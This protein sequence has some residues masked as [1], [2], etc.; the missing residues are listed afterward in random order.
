M[1]FKEFLKEE[2][3]K[4]YFARMLAKYKVKSPSELSD[5]DKK[6]FFDEVDAGWDGEDE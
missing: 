6:K 4:E 2:T 5:E 3:Y 1:K